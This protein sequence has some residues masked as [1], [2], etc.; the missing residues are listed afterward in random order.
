MAICWDLQGYYES[1]IIKS[2]IIID[3]VWTTRQIYYRICTV[4][5]LRA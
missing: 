5:P 4:E 1:K 2:Q 3:L